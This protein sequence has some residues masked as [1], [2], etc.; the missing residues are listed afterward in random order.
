MPVDCDP[1]GSPPGHEERA[2]AP[3]AKTR[4]QMV[5]MPQACS[6]EC[7]R[8]GVARCCGGLL[9]VWRRAGNA[10]CV[11]IS[12]YRAAAAYSNPH[13]DLAPSQPLGSH[14]GQGGGPHLRPSPLHLLNT[15]LVMAS[16]KMMQAAIWL[17]HQHHLAC[18]AC[19]AFQPSGAF[20]S[21]VQILTDK[22]SQGQ[23]AYCKTRC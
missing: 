22:A 1:H 3:A 17:H 2:L 20:R 16:Q 6:T 5:C 14:Q 23:I 11:G 4:L 21:T 18:L 8:S 10:A 9:S 12:S 7:A 15:I 13:C 19:V